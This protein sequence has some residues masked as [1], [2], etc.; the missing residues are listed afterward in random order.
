MSSTATAFLRAPRPG[1]GAQAD[2]NSNSS[3]SNS[4]SNEY[5]MGEDDPGWAPAGGA[6]NVILLEHC[7]HLMH[8]YK[9][10]QSLL[11]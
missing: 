8:D 2:G 3:G 1:W 10:G 11:D 9:H 4:D 6:G 5:A 7:A